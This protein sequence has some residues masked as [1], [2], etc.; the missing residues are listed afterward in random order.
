MQKGLHAPRY[1][2]VEFPGYHTEV[3]ALARLF[4]PCG[5]Q[6]TSLALSIEMDKG[7]CC[8]RQ[9]HNLWWGNPFPVW[10]IFLNKQDCQTIHIPTRKPT[11][12]LGF[13]YQRRLGRMP[14]GFQSQSL[15]HSRSSGGQ[16]GDWWDIPC[17]KIPVR[18][19]IWVIVVFEPGNESC[20]TTWT[21]L[22]SCGKHI[23]QKSEEMIAPML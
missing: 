22:P 7:D 16:A 14:P 10:S 1:N 2:E 3:L 20:S 11:L 5:R 17:A 18:D 4:H 9:S 21:T 15:N 6:N 13:F 8:Q 23:T 12:Y 19:G